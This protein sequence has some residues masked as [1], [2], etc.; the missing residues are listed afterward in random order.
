MAM[1]GGQAILKHGG[2]H[3]KLWMILG[4]CY[5][6]IQPPQL[7]DAAKAFDKGIQNNPRN[8]HL[9]ICAAQCAR[10]AGKLTKARAVLEKARVQ[11]PSN[12]LLWLAGVDVE[13]AASNEKVAHR[14]GPI[15]KQH[16]I[17]NLVLRNIGRPVLG[18]TDANVLK[19]RFV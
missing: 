5:E 19:P 17:P 15:Q 18:G 11:L 2:G 4:Q 16:I 13:T 8:V 1:A 3:P 12:E 9:W 14:H 10:K 7:D 6:E